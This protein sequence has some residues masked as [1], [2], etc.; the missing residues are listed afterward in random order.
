VNGL[1]AKPEIPGNGS[2]A[3]AIAEKFVVVPVDVLNWST[4]PLKKPPTKT[5]S[6]KVGTAVHTHSAAKREA[7]ANLEML[8]IMKFVPM[9]NML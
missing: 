5:I 4:E 3:E 1:Y 2:A 8:L 9:L 7:R 6:P